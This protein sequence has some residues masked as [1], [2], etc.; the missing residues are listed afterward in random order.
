MRFLGYSFSKP[1]EFVDSVT[2][3]PQ[4]KDLEYKIFAQKPAYFAV[5]TLC[6]YLLLVAIVQPFFNG[7]E[8]AQNTF[9]LHH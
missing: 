4:L 9:R 6:V 8:K 1:D 2:P 5:N 3:N 7:R